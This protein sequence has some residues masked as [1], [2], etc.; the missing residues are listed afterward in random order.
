MGDFTKKGCTDFLIE[1]G[2]ELL[3]KGR[4][5]DGE[6]WSIGVD[7][8]TDTINYADRFQFILNLDDKAIA[9]SGSYRKF[10]LLIKLNIVIPL[11]LL[12]VFLVQIVC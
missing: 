12:L 4:N 11:V 9:T 6:I 1:V 3:A 5:A 7:K 8:P 2:G 10:L